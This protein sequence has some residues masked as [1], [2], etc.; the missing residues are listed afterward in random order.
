VKTLHKSQNVTAK[1]NMGENTWVEKGNW[2][3]DHRRWRL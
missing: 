3:R 1:R 2:E